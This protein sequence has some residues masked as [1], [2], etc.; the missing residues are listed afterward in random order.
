M[1]QKGV[2]RVQGSEIWGLGAHM[3]THMGNQN[4]GSVLVFCSRGRVVKCARAPL[5]RRV[6]KP[7]TG[8]HQTELRLIIEIELN[9]GRLHL[10]GTQQMLLGTVAMRASKASLVRG[11]GLPW[12]G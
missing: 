6:L 5:L 7:T 1:G 12:K 8:S 2:L 11:V 3:G 10:F 9:R 4:Q